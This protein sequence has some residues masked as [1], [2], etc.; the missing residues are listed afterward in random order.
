[1][2]NFRFADPSDKNSVSDKVLWQIDSMLY[3]FI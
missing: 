2:M 3:G 1:M